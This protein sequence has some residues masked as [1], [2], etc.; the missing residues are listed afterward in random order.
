MHLMTYMRNEGS[1][2]EEF[3][4]LRQKL[5][6]TTGH[7]W[8]LRYSTLFRHKNNLISNWS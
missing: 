1:K 3:N 5:K 2:S 4:G 6:K 7:H 8:T